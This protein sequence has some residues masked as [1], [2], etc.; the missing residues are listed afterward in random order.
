MDVN[1][2]KVHWKITIKETQE[3][4]ECSDK[5]LDKKAPSNNGFNPFEIVIGKEKLFKK[6]EEAISKNLKTKDYFNVELSSEDSYGRKNAKMIETIPLREFTKQKINPYP[7]AVLDFGGISGK[8]LFIGSGRVTVDFNHPLASK[9][10][11]YDVKIIE[12]IKDAMG[13]VNVLIAPYKGAI[14]DL[15]VN[16]DGEKLVFES[17]T[18][19][20]EAFKEL[21]AEI[22]ELV[23]EVKEVEYVKTEVKKPAKTT[24]K[25]TVKKSSTDESENSKEDSTEDVNENNN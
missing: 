7:G 2:L 9:S 1:F 16:L 21:E 12:E 22:K 18:D 4:I 11:I 15:K 13:K 24:K 10:L 5:D 14:K 23:T 3:V 25:V 8:V 6:L 17:K 19:L 20:K